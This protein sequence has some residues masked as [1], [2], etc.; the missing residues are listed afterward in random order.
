M[1]RLSFTKH[2]YKQPIVAAILIVIVARLS[3]GSTLRDHIYSPFISGSILNTSISEPALIPLSVEP[4]NGVIIPL[5]VSGTFELS[6]S[7]F[8]LYNP[9]SFLFYRKNMGTLISHLLCSSFNIEGLPPEAVSAVLSEQLKD[10]VDFSFMTEYTY[11]QLAKKR[12]PLLKKSGFSFRV[13]SN[14]EA[15]LHIPGDA[16]KIV[17][18][19]QEGMQEGNKLSLSS[20]ESQI[21]VTTDF[22][23]AYGTKSN[24]QFQ[25]FNRD[26]KLS[27]GVTGD[28]K[29]GHMMLKLQTENAE[30]N[31][32]E[33]NV[34]SLDSKFHISSAGIKIS[35]DLKFVSTYGEDGV[36]NGHGIG[37]GGGLAI[38]SGNSLFSASLNELGFMAWNSTSHNQDISLCDDSLFIMDLQN[39]PTGTIEIGQ[40]NSTKTVVNSLQTELALKYSY[41]KGADSSASDFMKKLSYARA[42]NIGYIQRFIKN[43]SGDRKPD[44]FISLENELYRGTLPIRV[45]WQYQNVHNHSSFIELEQVSKSLT[46]SFWYRAHCDMLFRATKGGEIGIRTHVYW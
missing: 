46:V 36:I 10:G 38:Q 23:F 43:S 12:D 31:Y 8:N 6:N 45:G 39:N 15:T 7:K 33:N 4:Y 32:G 19:N 25:L 2:I 34:L 20:L 28:Y 37:L 40:N 5:P 44:F 18:S 22:S 24:K 26:C 42:C 30:L 21:M 27:F 9:L 3:F 1:S 13:Q 17:F 35:D 16:F 14:S 11:F 41:F 29:M